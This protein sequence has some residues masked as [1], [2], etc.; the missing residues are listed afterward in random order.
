MLLAHFVLYCSADMRERGVD[1]HVI[2]LHMMI[3]VMNGDVI[4]DHVMT[5]TGGEIH[6]VTETC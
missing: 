5:G 4:E 1:D 3:V 2:D 6:H